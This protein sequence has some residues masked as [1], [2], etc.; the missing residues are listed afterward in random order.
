TGTLRSMFLVYIYIYIYIYILR[1]KA[2]FLVYISVYRLRQNTNLAT[3]GYCL[4][5]VTLRVEP[6]IVPLNNHASLYC[7]YDLEGAPL[8]TVKWY[9]GSYEFYRYSPGENPASKI[10]PIAGIHVDVS[11]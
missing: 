5:N 3:D 8:Y 9:R 4:K 6:P 7:Y 2:M 10:F 11:N 1:F